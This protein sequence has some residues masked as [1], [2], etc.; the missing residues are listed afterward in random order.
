MK[1]ALMPAGAGIGR[2]FPKSVWQE[3]L[4]LFETVEIFVAQV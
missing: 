2:R 3:L 1:E 4:R